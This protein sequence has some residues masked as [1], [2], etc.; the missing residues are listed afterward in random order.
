MDRRVVALILYAFSAVS[1]HANV[2]LPALHLSTDEDKIVAKLVPASYQPSD[3]C[4][5]LIE[6]V[7]SIKTYEEMCDY[8]VHAKYS[9][10]VLRGSAEGGVFIAYVISWIVRAI[11][12]DVVAT[13]DSIE[14]HIRYWRMQQGH[15]VS[16]FFHKNPLKWCQGPAQKDEIALH[17]RSLYTLRTKYQTQ[18]GLVSQH[19][20]ELS[21]Q[22]IDK[23]LATFCAITSKA[24]E[25]AGADPLDALIDVTT[26]M[27][28][29]IKRIERDVALHGIPSHLERRW[30]LYALIAVR[31]PALFMLHTRVNA[32]CKQL[33]GYIDL[34][35]AGD[36]VAN[37]PSLRDTIDSHTIR[38][39]Q[40]ILGAEELAKQ[41]VINLGN[42]LI[43]ASLNACAENKPLI[44]NAVVKSQEELEGVRN[45]IGDKAAFRIATTIGFK[46]IEKHITSSIK[47]LG[48]NNVKELTDKYLYPKVIKFVSAVEKRLQSL[49]SSFFLSYIVPRMFDGANK[50]SELVE[51]VGLK[52]SSI[53]K[54]T[55]KYA[56]GSAVGAILGCIVLKKTYNRIRDYIDGTRDYYVVNNACSAITRILVAYDA[57]ARILSTP[58][59]GAL[60][61]YLHTLSDF[62]HDMPGEFKD[63]FEQDIALLASDKTNVY[64]KIHMLEAMY[65]A[66]PFLTNTHAVC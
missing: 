9:T 18:L 35:L 62:A 22:K 47:Y 8:L 60:L 57:D 63:Q 30:L 42:G 28:L 33:A 48:L 32:K 3:Q 23:L 39:V 10:Q 21:P 46:T 26:H 13:L 24:V 56:V 58:D 36:P 64:Q 16:Y 66:Y 54:T 11:T 27:P 12:Q 6:G 2:V 37:S 65:R 1:A 14:S 25:Q 40:K 31:M 29:C 34:Q 59:V 51:K 45:A 38:A 15:P 43:D 19:V 5:D 55:G 61:Y 17:L 44:D 4:T 41:K 50:T 52:A 20:D 7:A 53:V 49:E